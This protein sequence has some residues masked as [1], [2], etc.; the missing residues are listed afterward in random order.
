MTPPTPPKIAT[1]EAQSSIVSPA[2][3]CNDSHL[4]KVQNKNAPKD[5]I[6]K[7]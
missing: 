3:T 5:V 7:Y 2:S 1:T 6:N 4:Q